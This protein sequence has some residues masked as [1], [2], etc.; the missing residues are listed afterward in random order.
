M[1]VTVTFGETAVVVPCKGGWTVQDLI[2]Q[3]MRRYRRVLEKHGEI[4]VKIHHLEYPEGG[5]LDVDDLLSDLVEDKDKLVAVFQED[6]RAGTESPRETMSNGFS[7]ANPSPEPMHYYPH[8]EYEDPNRGEIEVNEAILKANTPLLVRSSSDPALALPHDSTPTQPP[9]DDQSNEFPEPEI[10]H[11]LTGASD[12]LQTNNPPAKMNQVNYSL[13]RTVELAGDQGPLGIHVVPYCSSL[14]GRTLGLHIKGIEENS[15]SK[16]ENIFKEDESIVQINDTPL[17]DK[18]FTQSQDVFRQA[19]MSSY[20]RLE[21]LPAANKPRYEKSLIGQLFTGDEKDAPPKGR[22][23]IV[24]QAQADPRPEPKPDLRLNAKAEARRPD[25]RSKTPEPALQSIPPVQNQSGPGSLERGSPTPPTRAANSSPISRAHN[26][27]P[28]ASKGPALPGPSNLT[29]RKGGKKFKIDLKKGAE[30]LGF[31]VVTRDTS[32]HGPGPILVKNILPRGA[33]VEDGRL[34]PGDRILE[35][36]GVDMTGRSQE[37]LVAMLRSTKQGE[38][39]H[40]VVARQEDIFLP[41]ELKGESTSSR[42]LEDGREQLMYEIPLNETGSAGLGVSLK[43]NKSRETG[44]DLG[45]FIKSIIHGGAAYKDGRLSMNDQMIAVNGESLLGRSN[46]SAMETLRRSMSF[47]G[48]AR[49]TIQLVVLRAHRQA[50]SASPS[51]NV[52]NQPSFQKGSSNQEPRG[53]DTYQKPSEPTPASNLESTM[54]GV[55]HAPVKDYA[56]S[57]SGSAPVAATNGSYGHHSNDD[58]EQS[59]PPPPSPGTMEEINRKLRLTLS[60]HREQPHTPASLHPDSQHASDK[61]NM[62]RNRLSKSMDLV[63]DE[64]NVG[65][66]VGQGNEPSDGGAMGPTL[67]LWKSSSLESLQ[68]A[69]SEA[70]HSRIQAQVP[71]HRPRPHMVRGRGCNQSFRNAIDKSYEGPSEDDDDMSDHSS[72]HETPASTSSRQEL[73]ADD[74]KKK[75]KTKGKKKEKKI[76]GKK[77]TEDSAEDPEKKSKKKG[78]GILRF[79]KKKEEKNKDAS[80]SSKNKLEALS[81]EELD[82]TADNRDGYDPRYAEV[83]SGHATPDQASLPDVEDDDSDPNYARISNFRQPPSPQS[84]ISRTPSPALQAGGPNLPQASS[85]ELDGLYAKVN[86]SR[87]P[88][89]LQNQLQMQADSDQHQQALRR[90]YQLARAAPG[91]E[92]LDA[93]R[94]RVLDHDPRRMAPRGA[95]SRFEHPYEDIG[96]HY[97]THPRRDPYDYPTHSRPAPREAAP[98]PSHLQDPPASS[99]PGRLPIPQSSTQSQPA[100]GSP[101]YYQPQKHHAALRQEVPPSPTTAHRG[102]QYQEAIRGRGDGYRQASPGRYTSPE[103]NPAVRDRYPSP[104]RHRY[105]DESQPDPRRKN[106]MIGAV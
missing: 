71:F 50:G 6:Q 34:Q 45:I 52:S 21:V 92:E 95:E 60:R 78:F 11:V 59:F 10:S 29:S 41:R 7:S 104:D 24:A 4:T 70:K 26:Q 44:E 63:A 56:H 84:F 13:T 8:L 48:N 86:K 66:L 37:E 46:H 14:S 79:G 22:N 106:P 94:R 74:G 54:N 75:K 91:Y 16:R 83:R 3:A 90:E 87:P 77:K 35:V 2:D 49:G 69:V 64:S 53:R 93:A 9:D 96:R 38:S 1:K 76:K 20:V 57:N 62:P 55:G 65:S 101:R 102:R 19:M 31:T 15:R 88:P 18:T 68:T 47:E 23:L 105:R 30:G 103:R 17:L 40:V 72:G 85:E 61:D 25:V 33:A 28:L 99:H 27:S 12:R 43:G 98:Y 32:V 100:P 36:N 89:V 80:K 5:I 58:D 97:P 73:D 67:G 42:A 82:G 39:V 51:P 81:E